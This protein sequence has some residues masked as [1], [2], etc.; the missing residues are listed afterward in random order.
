MMSLLRNKN[1]LTSAFII[2]VMSLLTCLTYVNLVNNQTA[3]VEAEMLFF[4]GNSPLVNDGE[5][6]I[7]GNLPSSKDSPNAFIVTRDFEGKIFDFSNWQPG[8][9]ETKY[10]KVINN[11]NTDLSYEINFIT[12]HNYYDLAPYLTITLSLYDATNSAEIINTNNDDS[13]LINAVDISNFKICNNNLTSENVPSYDIIE[14]NILYKED[15]DNNTNNGDLVYDFIMDF[16][17]D[18]TMG[19]VVLER[20]TE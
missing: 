12:S 15:A 7:S 16:Q 18:T 19:S 14:M 10:F 13:M 6:I 17:I 9:C 4:V 20:T 1:I 2:I 8:D 5:L 11:G 3:T